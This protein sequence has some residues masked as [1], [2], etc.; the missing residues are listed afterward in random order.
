MTGALLQTFT[1]PTG[2]DH[3]KCYQAKTTK[4]APKFVKRTIA[5]ADEIESKNVSVARP[6]AVC[7]PVAVDGSA[8][9]V[10]DTM[11]TCYQIKDVA[12][13]AAFPRPSF[14]GTSLVGAETPSTIEAD[15]VCVPS[16]PI[17]D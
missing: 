7:V 12:G 6:V 3:C 2:S 11:L 9:V 1:K 5:L 17:T 10:P 8:I 13:Q 16:Q 15:T 4:G 14:D